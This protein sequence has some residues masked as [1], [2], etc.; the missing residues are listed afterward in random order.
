MYIAE[1]FFDDEVRSDFFVDFEMKGAWSAQLEVLND[2]DGICKKYGL[3]WYAAWGTLL[4][5]V[6]HQ[7][8]IPW[9][10]DIDIWLLRE[11]YDRLLSVLQGEL[12]GSLFITHPSMDMVCN[13]YFLRVQNSDGFNWSKKFLE[14]YHGCPYAVGVDVYPLDDLYE[15]EEDKAF[16]R[17][18]VAA[19][20]DIIAMAGGEE[21]TIND[22]SS[23]KKQLARTVEEILQVKLN[24]DKCLLN[25]LWLACDAVYAMAGKNGSG[26][27]AEWYYYYEDPKKQFDRAWFQTVQYLPFE[28]MMVPVPNGYDNVLKAC[29]GDWRIQVRENCHDYPFY[30]KQ[31]KIIRERLEMEG[32]SPQEWLEEAQRSYGGVLRMKL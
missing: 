20:H 26:K 14:K 25:E 15:E 9:D 6:R 10:D 11:D 16:Q 24:W 5:A 8:F 17:G 2:I 22:S 27:L 32:R 12:D 30:A 31:K 3:Q 7:G 29:F 23:E 21:N 13:R 28:N 19:M 4:G 1:N 18:I